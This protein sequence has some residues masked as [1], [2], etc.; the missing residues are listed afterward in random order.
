M[1][2]W[3]FESPEGRVQLTIAGIRLLLLGVVI[4]VSVISIPP[5]NWPAVILAVS[6]FYL[7][8]LDPLLRRPPLVV[9]SDPDASSPFQ[10]PTATDAKPARLQL[11]IS[12]YGQ[13]P[14]YNCLCRLIELR[15]GD[16]QPVPTFA[17]QTLC[18]AQQRDPRDT[19]LVTIH[20]YGDCYY[21]DLA[22][23]TQSD[24]RLFF[25][26][27]GLKAAPQE[28]ADPIVEAP[29]LVPTNA[30][31]RLGIYAEGVRNPPIWLQITAP[32]HVIRAAPPRAQPA[33]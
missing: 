3:W 33:A 25:R 29:Q 5:A 19:G 22:E 12:N 6:G 20:G 15:T 13:T 16:G 24:D 7:G 11:K 9:S 23:Y 2:S 17:P 21:L 27:A 28:A 14:A 30:F 26:Y 4:F 32:G 8:V 18:W 31:V 10:T 1:R